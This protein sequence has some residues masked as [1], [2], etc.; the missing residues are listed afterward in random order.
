MEGLTGPPLGQD[1]QA[2]ASAQ[3]HEVAQYREESQ[4][5]EV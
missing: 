1:E 5:S 4:T 3:L 2:M